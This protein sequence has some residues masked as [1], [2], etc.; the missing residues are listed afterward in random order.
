M[1]WIYLAVTAFVY[2]EIL[3]SE[4]MIL[5]RV[6]K[7]CES[8]LPA[9]VHKPLI[10]CTYCVGGQLALWHSPIPEWE[11]IF[12]VGSVVALIHFLK[13]ANTLLYNICSTLPLFSSDSEGSS[14]HTTKH[15]NRQRMYRLSRSLRR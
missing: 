8:K 5:C 6:C 13:Y 3:T 2:V 7:W 11:T 10:S 14:H 4:G 9:W 15:P 1:N 12:R